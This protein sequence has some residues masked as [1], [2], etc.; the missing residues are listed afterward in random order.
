MPKAFKAKKLVLVLA[1][2][3]SVTGASKKA[4]K[5]IVLDRMPCIHYPV[6]F[7]KDQGAT[8]RALIN[9]GSKVNAMTLAYT[10]KLGLRT[11]KTDLRAQKIDG[12]LLKTYEMVIAA[13][14]VRDKL[15]KARFFQETF[16][17][18]DTS[19]EVVLEML[20]LIFSNADIQFAEK[21]LT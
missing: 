17:L 5:V 14:Q 20:F 8:I 21:E 12:S 3:A 11:Q 6:Q 4:Q 7:R 18:A 2:Y 15:G 16:L 1:A 13:F 9:S 19:M 10:K